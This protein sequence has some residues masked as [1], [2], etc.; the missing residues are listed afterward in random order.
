MYNFNDIVKRE[1]TSSVKYEEMGLKFG[2]NDLMPFWVADMDIKSPDFVIDSLVERAKHGVFGYTKRMPDYY[3]AI[4]GW[5]KDRHGLEV[6]QENIEYAPGVVFA[7]NMMIRCF[8]KPGEN[9][10]IQ[11]PVYYPFFSIIE[12]NKRN[13]KE[14]EL[15]FKEGKYQMD[16]EDLLEKAKDPNTTM[17]ILCSPHNPV[18]RVWTKEELTKL[19][20]ICI[21]NNVLVVSDEIHFDLVFKGNKHI[22]FASISEE[23]R[24]NSVT[25]TAPSKTFN[26]A[27]IHSAYCII[28]DEERMQ[29]YKNEIGLLDLNRSNSFSR[30]VTQAVY[31]NGHV[32]VDELVD[33]LEGNM[34]F[35]HDYITTNIKSIIPYKMEGTYLMWLDCKGLGISTEEVD[36]LF[37]NEAGLAL[38]SGHWFGNTGKGFMRI[39]IAC[40][41]AMVEGAMEKLNIAVRNI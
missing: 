28:F 9:I 23:F 30:E 16:F 6:K 20:E 39:N 22:P 7:L 19:G 31:E 10:I 5:L 40:P 41:R 26:I 14:N 34:N 33:H 21:E 27:G 29:T 32:W 12:G 3:G 15:L 1:N 37:I 4:S 18:G 17:L 36:N 24:K 35:I 38:D 2:R 8:T 13:I 25:C 11:T